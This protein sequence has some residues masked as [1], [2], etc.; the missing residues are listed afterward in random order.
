MATPPTPPST[1]HADNSQKTVEDVMANVESLDSMTPKQLADMLSQLADKVM[2]EPL[3]Y[4]IGFGIEKL[5][6]EMMDGIDMNS[7][8]GRKKLAAILR[9]LAQ[10][11]MSR[12]KSQY[13][14]GISADL[15]IDGGK[16]KGRGR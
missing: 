5:T 12:E 10:L 14:G 9:M 4:K 1:N 13:L 3:E 16:D 15:T 8:E 2:T 11:V 7:P 6:A